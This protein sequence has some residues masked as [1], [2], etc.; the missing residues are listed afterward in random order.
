VSEAGTAVFPGVNLPQTVAATD[1]STAAGEPGYL[2]FV[3]NGA[4]ANYLVALHVATGRDLPAY[5]FVSRDDHR[6]W[7][8][9]WYW[10][11]GFCV[12]QTGNVQ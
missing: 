4:E 7:R 8:R 10:A 12:R 5:F 9:N 2:Q 6:E 3:L 11:T 1:R